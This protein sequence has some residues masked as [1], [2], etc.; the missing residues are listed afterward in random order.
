MIDLPSHNGGVLLAFFVLACGCGAS[1]SQRGG[2]E[3]Y[4]NSEIGLSLNVPSGWSRSNAAS[5]IAKAGFVASFESPGHDASVT[6]GRTA[7][8]GSGCGA[9]AAEAVRQVTGASIA[10]VAE[11]E[12]GASGHNIPAGQGATIGADRE[13][14]VRY[15]CHDQT[16]VVVEASS[17]RASYPRNGDDLLGILDSMAFIGADGGTIALR[18]PAQRREPTFFVHV[19]KY[20]GETLAGLAEWYTGNVDN[21]RATARA[22]S[23]F[24]APTAT[25]K[26][27]REIKIP[28]MLVIRPEPMPRPRQ[29]AVESAKEPK[30]AKS[31]PAPAE[32]TSGSES[33]DAESADEAA[34]PPVIGPR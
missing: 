7:F 24:G 18:A 34:L 3:S 13:G 14:E 32:A 26:I 11:Y 25:L 19:V 23:D 17:P 20:K 21:W 28:T 22:N 29:K 5:G 16:T 2:S 9:S 12:V 33:A 27:G 15:F 6:V 10:T 1:T 4:E 8:T 30:A 31:A